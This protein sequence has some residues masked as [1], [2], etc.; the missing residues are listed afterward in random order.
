ME[1]HLNVRDVKKEV[2]TTFEIKDKV[3]NVLIAFVIKEEIEEH[4]GIKIM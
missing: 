4:E 2:L 1:V 3:E